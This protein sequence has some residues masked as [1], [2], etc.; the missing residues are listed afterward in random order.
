MG[1]ILSRLGIRRLLIWDTDTV[2]EHN[3]GNQIF[4]AKD[5]GLPKVDCLESILKEINP[6]IEV[7]KKGL[8]TTASKVSG[9]VFLCVDNIDIRRELCTGWK[10]NTNIK[11]VVDG[12]MALVTAS[13]YAA[14]W[15]KPTEKTN[16][17]KS[18]NYTHE[19]AMAA[20]PMTACGT[21]LSVVY[22]PRILAG[23]MVSN[24]VKFVNT[25]AYYKFLNIDTYHMFLD[26]YIQE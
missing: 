25:K 10:Y 17:L 12:R 20:T 16:M 3:L 15:N 6:E 8:C 9:Y 21:T 19:E 2:S 5:I 11:F 24:F 23:Y 18:M 14:N 26:A 7:V 22:A 4:R 1:E 13:M